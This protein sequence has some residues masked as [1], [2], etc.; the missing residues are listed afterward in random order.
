MNTRYKVVG[1]K[2]IKKE[3]KFFPEIVTIEE[4]AKTKEEANILYDVMLED[5]TMCGHVEIVDMAKTK[6]VRH[7]KE[8]KK[9]DPI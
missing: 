7:S 6:V 3:G 8:E 9:W 1:F 2:E 4:E 5:D